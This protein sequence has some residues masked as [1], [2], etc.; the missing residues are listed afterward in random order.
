MIQRDV[1]TQVGAVSPRW[2]GQVEP[3]DNKTTS[4]LPAEPGGAALVTA[5]ASLSKPAACLRAI[6]YSSIMNENWRK[7]A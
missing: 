2:P 3:R 7:L 6:V 4:T 1:F 5:F